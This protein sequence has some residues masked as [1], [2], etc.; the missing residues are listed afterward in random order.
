MSSAISF[1]LDQSKILS[2]GNGLTQIS[3]REALAKGYLMHL[4]VALTL[5]KT[6][7][8]WAGPNSKNLHTTN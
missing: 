3:R 5:Y 7:N 1:N 2:S 8:F 4:R 6:T